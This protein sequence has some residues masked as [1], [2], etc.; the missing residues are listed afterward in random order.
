MVLL[1]VQ[2]KESIAASVACVEMTM[3]EFSVIR[4]ALKYYAESCPNVLLSTRR[5]ACQ[6]AIDAGEDWAKFIELRE[7]WRKEKRHE[8]K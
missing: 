7:I 6:S 5:D 3:G 4:M 1:S 2:Q 8:N